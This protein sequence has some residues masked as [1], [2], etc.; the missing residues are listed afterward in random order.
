[1]NI[2]RVMGSLIFS[3]VFRLSRK[4]MVGLVHGVGLPAGNVRKREY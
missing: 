2:L 3:F 1:M 4:L